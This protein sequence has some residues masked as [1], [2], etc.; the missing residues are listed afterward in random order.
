MYMEVPEN[1]MRWISMDVFPMPEVTEEGE[2]LTVSFW[3]S[4][5]TAN[6]SWQFRAKRFRRRMRGT[7]TEVGR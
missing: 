7:K 4:I 6:T 5:A 1:P 3:Q 2:V